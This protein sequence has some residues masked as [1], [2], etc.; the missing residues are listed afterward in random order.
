MGS[1]H[2]DLLDQFNISKKNCLY[3]IYMYIFKKKKH[4]FVEFHSVDMCPEHRVLIF[5]DLKGYI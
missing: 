5:E 3:T 2:P 4:L 1:V